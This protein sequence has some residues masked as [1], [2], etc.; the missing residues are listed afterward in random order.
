ML[1]CTTW[2]SRPLSPDQSRRLMG[3]WA[4]TEAREAQQVAA[5]RLCWYITTDGSAAFTGSKV[6]DAEAAAK[7]QLEVS[8]ALGEFLELESKIVLG[9]ETGM[10]P[11]GAGRSYAS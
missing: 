1:V 7:L 9:V 11:I 3:V 6:S 2:K 4:K 5:E 8:I 10:A